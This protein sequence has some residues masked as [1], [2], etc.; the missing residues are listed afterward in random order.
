MDPMTRG[1]GESA[2]RRPYSLMIATQGMAHSGATK[3]R[4]KVD[5]RMRY[6][7]KVEVP[8][9]VDSAVLELDW[10]EGDRGRQ[11]S[12]YSS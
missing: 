7:S 10:E 6:Q 9:M 2:A 1:T 4:R 3:R 12:I 11:L 5:V 8:I